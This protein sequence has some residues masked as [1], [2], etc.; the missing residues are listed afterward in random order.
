MKKQ[1]LAETGREP[2]GLSRNAGADSWPRSSRA[3]RRESSRSPGTPFRVHFTP[4]GGLT[5][6]SP[7]LYVLATPVMFMFS[8]TGIAPC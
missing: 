5:Q 2:A 3:P 8:K 6:I 1:N 7:N 4:Q